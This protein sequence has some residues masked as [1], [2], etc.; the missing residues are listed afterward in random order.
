MVKL[1][2]KESAAAEKYAADIQWFMDNA[3]GVDKVRLPHR[4][5]PKLIAVAEA[6]GIDWRREI[7]RA[8]TWAMTHPEKKDYGRFFAGWIGRANAPKR[9]KVNWENPI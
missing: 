2:A 3:Y 8:S 1:T 9:K 6:A 4:L 7:L 5:I